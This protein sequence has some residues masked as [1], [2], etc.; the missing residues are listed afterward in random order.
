MSAAAEAAPVKDTPGRIRPPGNAL[1]SRVPEAFA[2][3]FGAL[4]PLCDT[5][6][7]R[8]F[9]MAPD[10]LGNPADGDCLLVEALGGDG[11][12][13]AL[14]SFVPWGKDCFSLDLMR[15][16]RAAPPTASWSPWS[17]NCARRPR[18]RASAGSP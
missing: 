4:G 2:T 6:T 9:S 11:G 18:R 1:L 12:L 17:P 3:F 13:L 16:D 10:H 15:R 8:G 5:E 14:L 7:E